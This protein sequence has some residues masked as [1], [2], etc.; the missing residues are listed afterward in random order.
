MAAK[1][2]QPAIRKKRATSPALT[3]KQFSTIVDLVHR[4]LA[5]KETTQLFV[6]L[7]KH[8]CDVISDNYF[9]QF[10]FGVSLYFVEKY[11]ESIKVLEKVQKLK[12]KDPQ[13]Y[14]HLGLDYALVGK[15]DK[16][17]EN[18]EKS[19]KMDPS[20]I[21]SVCCHYEIYALMNEYD[22][23]REVLK[24]ELKSGKIS[25]KKF[26]QRQKNFLNSRFCQKW[27]RKI[28]TDLSNDLCS[29]K[30]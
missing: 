16:A 9:P 19:I 15:F 29:S 25:L 2:K 7:L 24:K 26:C 10:Y 8:L 11:P 21:D 17:L 20:N 30:V 4:F 3:P 5:T 13:F 18:I 12:P 14:N 6:E 23:A 22:K 28:L 1:T 27:E